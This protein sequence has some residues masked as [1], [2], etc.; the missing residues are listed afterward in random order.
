MIKKLFLVAIVAAMTV[1]GANAQ[2]KKFWVGG[3]FGYTSSDAYPHE[4]FAIQPEVG[5]KLSERWAA[6]MQFRFGKGKMDAGN[7]H[8]DVQTFG[9][10]PVARYTLLR[11]KALTIFTKG[12]IGFWETTG[13][14]DFEDL[15]NEDISLT[16]VGL[17]VNPGFSLS[18]TDRIALAGSTN[19]FTCSYAKTKNSFDSGESSTWTT[20][21]NSPF[22]LDGIELGFVFK[23]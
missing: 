4:A 8:S 11:W 18:L 13:D 21:F 23:F 2:E 9:I 17:F 6:G 5:Y 7:S 20:N 12:I 1:V 22:N 19:L 15:V 14:T 10:A 16:T 3:T